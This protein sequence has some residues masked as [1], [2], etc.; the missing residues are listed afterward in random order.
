MGFTKNKI[1]LSRSLSA[2][3]L[4]L[5]MVVGFA[6]HARAALDDGDA[7]TATGSVAR[8]A[9]DTNGLLLT[10]AAANAVTTST[11]AGAV[12]F[13]T[14]GTT[15]AITHLADGGAAV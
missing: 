9:T 14:H 4:S 3:T 6:S 5:L 11:T 7:T 10:A 8:D 12:V 13:G 2:L 15:D 1:S